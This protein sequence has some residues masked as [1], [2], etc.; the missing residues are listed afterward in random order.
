MTRVDREPG[1]F[2][3]LFLGSLFIGSLVVCNLIATKF[4]EVDL[5]FKTFT[6]SVGIL[7]YPLTFLVTDILSEI[8]GKKRAS[9]VVLCGFGASVMVIG[10]VQLALAFDALNFGV[11]DAAF[12]EVFGQTWRV[13]TAS[14]TAYLVAQL[15]DVQ[16]FHF[17]KN[18]TKGKHLWLRN[19]ASTICSQLLDTT[20]VVSILFWDDPKVDDG[21]IFQMIRDGWIFKMLCALADTP[22]AYAAVYLLRGRL[23]APSDARN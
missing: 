23:A 18:L 1:L 8:Y 12:H 2:G 14:M 4:T 6:I 7:P 17:W 20:L 3:L 13:I 19:N 9:Q 10:I 21:Q 5:G 16:L 15:V 11:G 22:L